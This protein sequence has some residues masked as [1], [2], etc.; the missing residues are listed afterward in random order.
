M[1]PLQRDSGSACLAPAWLALPCL[2]TPCYPL[3]S[4]VFC[5][6]APQ[7]LVSQNLRCK[8]LFC[9]VL[10]HCICLCVFHIAR[11]LFISLTRR[12]AQSRTPWN[13]QY[14]AVGEEVGEGGGDAGESVH[15]KHWQPKDAPTL[16]ALWTLF[17]G[18]NLGAPLEEG[19][20]M[21]LSC[22]MSSF[23]LTVV[24]CRCHMQKSRAQQGEKERAG[25]GRGRLRQA[26]PGADW[27]QHFW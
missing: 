19:L 7:R 15:K 25:G 24:D 12:K 17:Y 10:S 18:G 5:F 13:C 6:T 22:F 23:P 8:C 3:H 26:L 2:T 21:A 11:F 27:Q 4:F 16:R 9:C 1:L 14:A 20:T